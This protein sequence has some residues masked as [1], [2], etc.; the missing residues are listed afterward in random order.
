LTGDLTGDS[1]VGFADL[2]LL[3]QNY[4][5]SVTNPQGDV[6]GDGRVDFTD[7]LL[8]AQNYGASA[9]VAASTP[10][11]SDDLDGQALRTRARRHTLTLK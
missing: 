5:S 6:N 10:L 4:G 7:L 3:A 1:T 2:L 8:L 9:T 11:A